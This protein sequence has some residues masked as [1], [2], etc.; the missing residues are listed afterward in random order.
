M[1]RVSFKHFLKVSKIKIKDA[2]CLCHSIADMA[3]PEKLFESVENW[4]SRIRLQ[5]H[6]SPPVILV[7]TKADL[8]GSH[9]SWA[10][11]CQGNYFSVCVC[12]ITLT[13][14]FSTYDT[15]RRSGESGQMLGKDEF[16]R[17]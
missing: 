15:P 11:K 16:E 10:K 5:A 1:M 12:T 4:L 3:N 13:V 7:G 17:A 9:D 8:A 6:K 14:Y 2:V